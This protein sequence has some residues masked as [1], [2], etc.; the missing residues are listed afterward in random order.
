MKIC[1]L[2]GEKSGD[3]YGALLS[4]NLRKLKKEVFIFGTGGDAMRN[5]GVDLIEGMPFGVM[6]F[7][8]VI[9]KIIPYYLFLKKVIKRIKEEKP[10][11]II[12]IDNPAFNLRVAERLKGE[13]KSYY[14]IPPKIWAYKKYNIKILKKYIDLVIPIFPFEIDIYEKENIPYNYFGH[15]FVDLFKEDEIDFLEIKGNQYLIGILPGSRIEEVKYNLPA[16]KKILENL[17]QKIEFTL[18]ISASEKKIEKII[19]NVFKKTKL[20]YLIMD[21]LYKLIKN[22]NIILA[23]SGTVNLE[24]AYLEK[25]MIIFYKTSFLNYY[26]AKLKVKLKAISPVNIILERKV[27][28]EYIQNFKIKDV[29][30]N[31]MELLNK[32]LLYMKEL[33]GYKKLKE[34]IDKKNVSENIA[35]FILKEIE[36]DKRV[37]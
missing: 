36:I 25:P 30:E 33:N 19:K 18:L 12:F 8:G 34:I 13:F 3:N 26:I 23:V 5:E 35:N 32:G 6:G 10:D 24:V 11:L 37:F 9:K 20:K 17:S 14:Y 22:S 29:S 4:K 7:S 27:I 2:S 15:P 31:I 21:D 28:P 16:I 1:I